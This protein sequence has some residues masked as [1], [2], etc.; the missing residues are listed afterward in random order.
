[1]WS[2]AA[3]LCCLPLL[4]GC[5]GG[6]DVLATVGDREI[7]ADYYQDRLSQLEETELPPDEDGL[8]LD[9][10]SLESKLA[11][12]NV[13]VNKEL[14]VLKALELGY[15]QQEDMLN[16]QSVLTRIKAN[17]RMREDLI[18]VTPDEISPEDIDH[19]YQMRQERRHFQ[20][21]ICNFEDDALEARQKI[22]DGESWEAVADEYNDGSKG[23]TGDYRMSVQYGMADD[24]FEKALFALEEGEMSMPIETVYGYWITRFSSSEPARERP[25]D[26]EY[27]ERIRQ[28][29]AGQRTALSERAFIDDSLERHEFEMDEAA[30]WIVFQGMPEGEGYLDEET[31]QPIAKEKLQPLDVPVEEMDR[32]LFSVRPQLDSEPS[33]W[34]IGRYKA[35]FDGMSVFQRPKRSKMLGGVRNQI[36]TDMV[37]KFMLD[38]EAEERGFHE[39]SRV[40]ADVQSKVEEIMVDRF[41][42]E[43]IKFEE[44]VSAD[45]LAAFWS[46]HSDQYIV[47]EQRE[48]LIVICEDEATATEARAA[49]VAGT[50][51]DEVYD[52]YAKVKDPT[53]AG[54]FTLGAATVSPERDVLFGLAEVGDVGEAYQN[55]AGWC[56]VR[57]V[58]IIP[59]VQKE[60]AEV[61]EE[62]GQ[63]I[64]LARKDQSLQDNL[65]QWREEFGVEIDE[66][67]LAAM[68]SW[69]ELQTVQ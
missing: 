41:Y 69:E 37:V 50:P 21:I 46:E 60:L 19:Y 1:L 10:A 29:L 65:A 56:V 4:S 26:D 47:P 36:V 61:R 66:G 25:L 31:N 24:V 22:I 28:T 33:V 32:V 23:P 52:D 63:R 51:W 42:E 7:T 59:P 11:F 9:T 30:L 55:Q 12:L 67:A 40:A 39:D 34:T 54:A 18:V 5:G 35:T 17:E 64:R 53:N 20:F 45:D 2:L 57:L 68:P 49:L 13:I 16:A 62:L 44:F 3:V 15:D 38:A 14:M 8:M 43:V 6:G 27:R 58:N 48:G